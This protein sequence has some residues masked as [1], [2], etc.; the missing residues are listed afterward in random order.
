MVAVYWL[1]IGAQAIAA[2]PLS[3]AGRAGTMQ[4]RLREHHCAA[5]GCGRV[6]L[7]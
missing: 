7:K 6:D 4:Y 5:S 1:C 2:M 3:E